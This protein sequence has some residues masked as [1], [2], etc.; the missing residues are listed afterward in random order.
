MIV[1]V[2]PKQWQ[3]IVKVTETGAQVTELERSR[4]LN[5]KQE[6]DR[7]QARDQLKD[8]F[9]VWFSQHDYGTVSSAL[10]A[11]G[12]CWGPYQTIQQ[13]VDG[14]PDCSTDNPLFNRV[15]QPGIGEYL[16]PSNPICFEGVARDTVRPA[17]LLG[18]HTD[19]ILAD[20]LGLSSAEIGSLHDA[21]IVAGQV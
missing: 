21:G 13:M 17:P 12:V 18:Q 15:Q 19:E 8:L 4:A 20:T 7:F 6:G 3:A 10:E 11:A 16:M 2:S 9:S 14:D 1:G 5:F